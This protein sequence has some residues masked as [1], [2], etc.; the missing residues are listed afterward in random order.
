MEANQLF[1]PKSVHLIAILSLSLSLR[2]PETRWWDWQRRWSSLLWRWEDGYMV[3]SW[4]LSSGIEKMAAVGKSQWLWHSALH[5]TS[6]QNQQLRWKHRVR[7]K[8]PPASKE[9]VLRVSKRTRGVCFPGKKYRCNL[10][11][12]RPKDSG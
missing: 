3:G 10:G 7:Q 5:S 6:P 9:F 4:W 11:A 2:F 8:S 12:P 1:T